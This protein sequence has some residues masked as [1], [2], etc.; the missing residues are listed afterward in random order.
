MEG[1]GRVKGGS[2]EGQGRCKPWAMPLGRHLIK[3]RTF[4][5]RHITIDIDKGHRTRSYYAN[6]QRPGEFSVGAPGDILIQS[7]RA[8]RRAGLLFKMRES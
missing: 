2:V 3:K 1:Q 7:L 8:F 5:I 4:N 6:G